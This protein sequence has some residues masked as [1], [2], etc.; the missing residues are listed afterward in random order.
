MNILMKDVSVSAVCACPFCHLVSV[1]I[2]D[3]FVCYCDPASLPHYVSSQHSCSPRRERRPGK[4]LSCKDSLTWTT[5]DKHH[6]SSLPHFLSLSLSLLYSFISLSLHGCLPHSVFVILFLSVRL[7]FSSALLTVRTWILAAAVL[8]RT[9][10][11]ESVFD[12]GISKRSFSD[13]HLSDTDLSSIV[14]IMMILMCSSFGLW[15][16]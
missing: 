8:F 1:L 5:P 2:A 10:R 11:R 15:V 6:F 14:K 16:F 7:S 3:V 4:M 12:L 13:V 9:L